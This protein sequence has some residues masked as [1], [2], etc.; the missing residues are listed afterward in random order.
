[1]G[2]LLFAVTLLAALGSGLV[3][4]IFFAFSAF[5]MAALR[6]LPVEG[7]IA[8]MQSINLTVLN[9]LFF[10][11]FFG[12]AVLP[13]VLG[14]AALLRWSEPGAFY[15]FAA[16]LL[17]LFGTIFVT[18]AFNVPLNNRLAA[19]KPGSAEGASLWTLYLSS[20]TAW[21]HVRT[22]ASLAACALFIMALA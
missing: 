1:M 11:V 5:V 7:G 17:Y 6:R 18:M 16:S 19:I 12:T 14:I 2:H 15:L 13:L 20:W 8:S 3:A 4:G 10:T 22:A 21:N 9:P